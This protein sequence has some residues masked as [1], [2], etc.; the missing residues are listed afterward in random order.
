MS[1][2]P[3]KSGT[4]VRATVRRSGK[5]DYTDEA[6]EERERQDG[7]TGIVGKHSDSHGL[8]YQVKFDNAE[9]WFDPEELEIVS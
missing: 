4:R 5:G 9:A 2:P 3:I 1:Y 8:C 6:I 7:K